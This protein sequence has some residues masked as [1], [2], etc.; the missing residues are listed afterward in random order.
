MS[1]KV[2]FIGMV[3]FVHQD[4]QSRIALLPDG[5]TPE[6]NVEPHFASFFVATKDK[7]KAD[8]KG[9]EIPQKKRFADAGV[10]EYR[11]QNPATITITGVSERAQN[12]APLNTAAHEGGLPQVKSVNPDFVVDEQDPDAIARLSIRQGTMTA[13][14]LSEAVVSQ[15]AS[16]HAGPITI[17]ATTPNGE[18]R[19]IEL[20]DGAEI[21]FSNTSDL[22]PDVPHNG[23][24]G[25]HFQLYAK[26]DVARDRTKLTHTPAVANLPDIPSDHPYIE[27]IFGLGEVPHSECSN[28][29][30]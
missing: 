8:W 10:I 14:K 7:T 13:F 11:I 26:L 24:S 25:N 2:D 4:D 3:Y 22:F 5:A 15:L 16:Q 20:R 23:P 27:L 18:R 9:W 21:V 28:T 6:N 30:C 1:F 29:C 19:T 12:R 17:K